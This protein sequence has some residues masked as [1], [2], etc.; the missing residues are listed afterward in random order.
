[1]RERRAEIWTRLGVQ[2]MKM[3]SLYVSDS[4]CRFTY[5]LDYLHSGLPGLG[6]VY[7]PAYFG[8]NTIK[9][10]RTPGFDFLPPLQALIPPHSEDNF[11]RR[12]ILQALRKKGVPLRDRFEQ[13]WEILM[14]AGHGG[15]GHLD[16]F[17]N[18]DEA[19]QWYAQPSGKLRAVADAEF[20]FSLKE[21]LTWF[22]GDAE[23]LLSIIGP[24]PSVGGMVPKLLLAIPATG[25]N[26]QIGLPTRY[27]DTQ[28]T[29]I[30][31]KLEKSTLYPGI[32][33]LEALGLDIHK[34]AGLAVPRY[35]RVD[36]SGVPGIAIERFDRDTQR[37]PLFMESL[38]SILA[39]ADPGIVTPYDASYDRIGRALN[40]PDIQLVTERKAAVEH[41]LQRLL[42][43]LLTGNGDLHLANLS[44]LQTASGTAFS[45]VYDPVPMR[46]YSLHDA[47]VP[48][49]MLFG[50]YSDYIKGQ[51]VPVSFSQALPRFIKGLGISK[52][53]GR[54]II[55][56]ALA[57]TSDFKERVAALTTLPA[58]HKQ[59]LE[60]IHSEIAYKLGTLKA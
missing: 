50:D 26:G 2:P 44:L 17:A 48:T 47:L 38:H 29:D 13:D 40:S 5:E 41:L 53:R 31:L 22:D 11:I 4:Q 36:L 59:R 55:A 45:P 37:V 58:E 27:G 20:G 18:D 10:A 19:R 6:L 43:A 34:A 3:G 30:V 9:R 21:F 28:N 1:M 52:A 35:W 24:T 60:Q 39:S 33:E 8:E 14:L 15:I 25:W 46:A 42:L 51:D 54:A 32:V 57:D 16:V 7:A 49:G 23:Q 56:K 12:L